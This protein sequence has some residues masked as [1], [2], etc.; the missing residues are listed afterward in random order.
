MS[1]ARLKASVV[2]GHLHLDKQ[3]SEADRTID[4]SW[5]VEAVTAGKKVEIRNAV[6]DGPLDLKGTSIR[7]QIVLQQCVLLGPFELSCSTLSANLVLSST[8]FRG[9]V[10]LRNATVECD[11]VLNRARFEGPVNTF[12]NMR[13]KGYLMAVGAR[14]SRTANFDDATFGPDVNFNRSV[15]SRVSFNSVRVNGCAHFEKAR[16]HDEVNFTGLDVEGDLD[17]G[18]AQFTVQKAA[19][20]A[21]LRVGADASFDRVVFNDRAFFDGSH[22]S[23]L[24]SFRGVQFQNGASFSD[25]TVGQD[26]AFRRAPAP[27]TNTVFQLRGAETPGSRPPL[28]ADF[29]D[30]HISGNFDFRNVEVEG[31]ASFVG[32]VVGGGGIFRRARFNGDAKVRFDL[33]QFRGGAFFQGTQFNGETDFRAVQIDLDARFSGADFRRPASFEASK[34]TG[35]VTFA[36]GAWE[37]DTYSGA[38]CDRLSFKHT[39]FEQDAHFDDAVF[40]G[41]ADFR[42]AA[43]QVIYFAR[44][45]EVPAGGVQ[46]RQFQGEVDLRGC[47]YKAITADWRSLLPRNQTRVDYNRQPYT[48]LEKFY[49]RI[50]ES[51]VADEVYLERSAA[52]GRWKWRNRRYM[53]GLSNAAYLIFLRYGVRPWQL[54]V[55][56]ALLLAYGTL[57]FSQPHAVAAKKEKTAPPVVLKWREAFELSVHQFLPVETP[58][59]EQWVPADEGID[60]KLGFLI[61]PTTFAGLFLRLPGWTLV[62]LG[63]ASFTRLLRGAGSAKAG[64]GE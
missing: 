44:S 55:I 2:E 5:I 52:E 38:T 18:E 46:V 29:S 41:D 31:A 8:T 49:A 50:G 15:F 39:R 26:I 56:A 47:T 60:S 20:F 32:L 19:A 40:R 23:G 35:L 57:F 3:A 11:V 22:I 17:F 61:K 25:V 28:A 4:A 63:I 42:D 37:T 9:P 48:Q 14:F 45:A 36:G 54:L 7:G 34:F 21:V 10:D 33:A 51:E 24:A 27:G 16:F 12:V 53:A 43:F 1:N 6:I 13:V 30:A 64:G 59:G 62:P 58:L